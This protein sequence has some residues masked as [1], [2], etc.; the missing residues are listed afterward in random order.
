MDMNL[1]ALG[2]AAVQDLF[3]VIDGKRV[4]GGVRLH[5]CSL[6]ARGSTGR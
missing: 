5:E 4:G 1:E 6:V 2:A 3:A